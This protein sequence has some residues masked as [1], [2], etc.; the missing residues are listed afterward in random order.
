MYREA[1]LTIAQL[2]EKLNLPE[3]RLRTFIHRELGFRNFNA[4]LHAYR[5]E[6]ASQAL[7]DADKHGV[8]VLTIA[9]SVGYQSITPFNNAF[10]QIMGVTPSEYR[11]QQAS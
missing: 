10:R 2:A 11:K 3:Y 7:V 4:M 8:P 9:L 1:G 6:E 5:V